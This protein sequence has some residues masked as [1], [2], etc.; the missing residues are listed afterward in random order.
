M[1]PPFDR[2]LLAREQH[3]LAD[4]ARQMNIPGATRLRPDVALGEQFAHQMP[5]LGF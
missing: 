3:V 4:L 1:A 5:Y 2:A